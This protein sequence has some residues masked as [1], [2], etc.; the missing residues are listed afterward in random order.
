[1]ERYTRIPRSRGPIAVEDDQ[2]GNESS[3]FISPRSS[4]GESLSQTLRKQ[5][6]LQTICRLSFSRWPILRS[7]QLLRRLMWRCGLIS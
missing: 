2:A 4:Q 3:Y 7:R 1:M 5:K 6:P